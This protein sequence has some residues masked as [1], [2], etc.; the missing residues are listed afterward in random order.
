MTAFTEK[1]G[2]VEALGVLRYVSS[3]EQGGVRQVPAGMLK[4]FVDVQ[5]VK[6]RLEEAAHG[7]GEIAERARALLEVWWEERDI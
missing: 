3:S 7:G 2:L 5:V 4:H 1:E 6:E